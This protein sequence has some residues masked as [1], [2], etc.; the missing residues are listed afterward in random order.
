MYTTLY[1]KNSYIALIMCQ[2]LFFVIYEYYFVKSLQQ[3]YKVGIIF[4][5][6]F[7]MGK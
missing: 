4:I 3:A 2:A 7:H 5:S 1:K 6:I